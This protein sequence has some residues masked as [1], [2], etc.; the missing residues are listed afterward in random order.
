[1]NRLNAAVMEECLLKGL[2]AL[3]PGEL[4]FLITAGSG[5]HDIVAS[6]LAYRLYQQTP[7]LDIQQDVTASQDTANL[8]AIPD[9]STRA[10]GTV[11]VASSYVGDLQGPEQIAAFATSVTND[12]LSWQ[13]DGTDK[14]SRYSLVLIAGTG[15]MTHH[16]TT[17]S[18]HECLSGLGPVRGGALDSGASPNM[19]VDS[20]REARR[21]L[22]APG[23]AQD[24]AIHVILDYLLI[25]P[26]T[27]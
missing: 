4:A 3:P 27:A 8:L 17:Q 10:I 20:R 25:G 23:T 11:N 21:K 15:D 2:E 26:F 6:T 16:R 9:N 24:N 7:D 14:L 12:A 18:V 5:Y 19:F 13:Q 22:G 1:M